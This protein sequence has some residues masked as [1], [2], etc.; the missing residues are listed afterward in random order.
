MPGKELFLESRV[1]LAE[2]KLEYSLV[3]TSFFMDYFGLPNCPTPMRGLYFMLDV[4]A[5]RA[6]VPGDGSAKVA[7]T[8][9]SDIG[10][11]IAVMLNLKKWDPVYN[12]AGDFVTLGE[13]VE[14]AERVVGKFMSHNFLHAYV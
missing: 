4:P 9:T 8:L 5:R 10:K 1:A 13:V 14:I 3:Y 6:V 12:I 7:F 2:T 11:F